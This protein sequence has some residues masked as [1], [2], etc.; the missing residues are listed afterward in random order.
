M[1]V[2]RLFLKKKPYRLETYKLFIMKRNCF[3]QNKFVLEGVECC[4]NYPLFN[5]K[6]IFLSGAHFFQHRT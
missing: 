4:I 1:N 6:S 2:I 3:I 5:V